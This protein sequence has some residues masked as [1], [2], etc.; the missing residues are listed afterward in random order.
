MLHFKS[1][2]FFCYSSFAYGS[3]SGLLVTLLLLFAIF[4]TNDV[5][6]K[7][8]G[9][10]HKKKIKTQYTI[11]IETPEGSTKKDRTTSNAISKT[12][13]GDGIAVKWIGRN[14]VGRNHF[15]SSITI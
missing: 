7:Q 10:I 2:L 1:T 4:D 11:H 15:C 8:V 3:E 14:P 5:N 9:V 12:N 6:R 13:F